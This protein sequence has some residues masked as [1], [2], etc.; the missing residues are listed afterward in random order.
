MKRKALGQKAPDCA[1]KKPRTSERLKSG[2][3]S[4]FTRTTQWFARTLVQG[5]AA[6]G[7]DVES[8]ELTHLRQHVH[9]LEIQLRKEAIEKAEDLRQSNGNDASSTDDTAAADD[10]ECP[11]TERVTRVMGRA[12]PGRSVGP[13]T[14]FETGTDGDAGTD[15]DYDPEITFKTRL[16]G[17]K[18]FHETMQLRKR[19]RGRMYLF[20]R[21]KTAVTAASSTAAAPVAASSAASSTA[22]SNADVTQAKGTAVA[23][24]AA[25]A[26]AQ[27]QRAQEPQWQAP[28]PQPPACGRQAQACP[29]AVAARA[30][31]LCAMDLKSAK[32][33]LRK[34]ATNRPAAVKTSRGSFFERA[35]QR[36]FQRAFPR[37][38]SSA[39]TTDGC[40]ATPA[41]DWDD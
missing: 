16:T 2:A 18:C 13:D 35:L 6:Y 15:P 21:L 25:A 23:A 5:L 24:A 33:G 34:T 27:R 12:S 38:C 36:K 22:S 17:P 11:P 40:P 7:I 31:G 39:N 3:H 26:A 30:R 20:S 8:D 19:G 29:P 14:N 10:D 32:Q 1:V 4:F 41:S 28:P 37:K 9:R